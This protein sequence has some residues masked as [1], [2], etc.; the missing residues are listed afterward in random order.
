MLKSK[1]SIL[2]LILIL[3]IVFFPLARHDSKDIYNPLP[4][5]DLSIGYYQSTTCNI[6][7]FEVYFENLGVENIRYSAHTYA[8]LE[9]YG[10]VTGVDKVGDTFIV[11]IGTNPSLSFVIQILIWSFLL[12]LIK[13]KDEQIFK[14][15]NLSL[16][17]LPV[18]FTIQQ[19]SEKRFYSYE[20]KYFS[21]EF[22]Q[23]NYN[24]FI[25]FIAIYLCSILLNTFLQTRVSN[26]INYSPFVFVVVGTFNGFNLNFYILLFSLLGIN[27]L[28]YGGINSRLNKTYLIFSIFWFFSQKDTYTFFDTDKIRG[29]INSSN[30]VMS[31]FYWV[32]IIGLLLNG[33]YLIYLKSEIDIPLLVRN[34]LLSGSLMVLFGLL[35]ANS[36]LLNFLNFYIFGQN[37]TGMRTFESID[38]NTWRGFS[39]SAESAG[40]F[41]GFVIILYFLCFFYRKVSFAYLDAPMLVIVMFGLYK[42][43]NFAALLSLVLL[44]VA[45]VIYRK[46]NIVIS[47][48][49]FF[50]AI[51]SF[52]IIFGGFILGNYQYTY[53]STE[54]LY[55]ASLH[56]NLYTEQSNYQKTVLI[57][58]FFDAEDFNTLFNIK[59]PNKASSTLSSLIK[60][61]TPTIGIP[62]VPNLVSLVSISS[63]LIN[64][65]EMW[66]IYIAK[67][68]PNFTETLFGNGPNQLNN[69]LYSHEVRLDLPEQK[70]T[71][72]YLPHSSLLDLYIFTGLVG[73]G[74]MLFLVI[75]L[76]R[77]ES[78]NQYFKIT[79]IF[80]LV[81]FIKSDSILYVN[82]TLLLLLSIVLTK[83]YEYKN[84]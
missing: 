31:Q 43:N 45:T 3:F 5:D 1:K 35:G 11:S 26:I 24:L 61:Y 6:S 22:S 71:S 49:N 37:K 40:E 15:A 83:E 79:V 72:L 84:E 30:N 59:N 51:I 36:N 4:V 47:K 34:C 39:A 33:F 46:F 25:I 82:S 50:I 54:L 80:L 58:E 17:I 48:R 68:S 10:K 2:S 81:N 70:L 57:T 44:T 67:Y 63:I 38:G 28:V 65:T 55:E 78:S 69:Y 74:M 32:L 56:S 27:N 42:T 64:R 75:R 29:F 16:I 41:Y 8:G 19:F 14:P 9:C 7:L 60:I 23:N 53:L 77:K 20:N 21:P 66:G 62:L 76:L 73:I 52:F 12:F 13:K 18:I